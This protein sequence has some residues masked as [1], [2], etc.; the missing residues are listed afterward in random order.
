MA[1]VPCVS[2]LEMTPIKIFCKTL[3]VNLIGVARITKTFIPLV[4]KAKGRIV[5][6]SSLSGEFQCNC[7]KTM[8]ASLLFCSFERVLNCV[9]LS[10]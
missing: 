8:Y 5:N 4:R 1:E 7:F 10:A 9:C 6:L 3:E 2:P